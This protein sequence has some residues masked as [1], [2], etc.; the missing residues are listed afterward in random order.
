MI[1]VIIEMAIPRENPAI[2]DA[3]QAMANPV[4]KIG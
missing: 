4:P 3:I 2:T 1:I